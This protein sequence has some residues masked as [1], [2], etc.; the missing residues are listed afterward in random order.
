MQNE[1]LP[2]KLF[3]DDRPEYGNS[4]MGQLGRAFVQLNP[5]NGAMV[6]QIFGDF[7][8]I[9]PQM[10]GEAR[11]ELRSALRSAATA[12]K[13]GDADSKRLAG[14]DVVMSNLIGIR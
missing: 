2:G 7:G 10:L 5:A 11:F 3:G 12:Q 1:G 13:I 9:D 8:L 14:F 4:K 6:L